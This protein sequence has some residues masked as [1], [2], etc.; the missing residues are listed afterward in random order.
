MNN[1]QQMNDFD[2]LKI[3]VKKPKTERIINHY[4]TF[5]WTLKSQTE[6]DRYEDILDLTFERPHKIKNKDELQLLQV[7]MEDKLNKLG[8]IEKNKAPKTTIFSLTFGVFGI[9]LTIIGLLFCFN[10][11]V[12]LNLALSIFIVVLGTIF[13]IIALIIIPQLHKKELIDFKQKSTLIESEINQVCD[14]A[15]KLL[16]GN[17][18]ESKTK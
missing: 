8:M 18:N 5:G 9:A 2:Y 6:N 10:Q 11:L 17:Q 7:Y 12:G 3:Y 15:T 16:G 1:S 14:K 4:K 13:T